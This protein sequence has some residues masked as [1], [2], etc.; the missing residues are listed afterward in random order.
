MKY[1]FFISFILLACAANAQ[2]A[3]SLD[4]TWPAPIENF[5][6]DNL[7]NLYLFSTNQQLKKLDAKFDSVCM[8][9]DVR[10]YGSLYAIDASNPLR[11]ILW[12]KDFST[13]VILDR[14]LNVRTS[15]NLN[16][17][18][19]LQ[20][21]AVAQSYDNNIWL[22]DD[23]DNKLKK[24][25]EEGNLLLESADFRMLF[26]NPPHPHRLEDFNKQLYAYDSTRG[27]LLMDYFGAYQ[28]LLPYTGWK[29]LQGVGKGLTATDGTNF[30]Y[31]KAD[32]IQMNTLPMPAD[33]KQAKKIRLQGNHLFVQTD[34]G[35]L[36]LY[37]IHP[38][39]EF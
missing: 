27:L 21:G 19:I 31:L 4:K 10:R 38:P 2:P 6:V 18:G 7:G 29:N 39:S 13:L 32:G 35:Y 25:D 26:D 9:N 5:E 30:I 12:Y 36:Q 16:A 15:I 34:K 20:C 22:F 11:I 8:F 23:L 17:V 24:I 37:T 3:F 1:F 28:K 33:M 14:F